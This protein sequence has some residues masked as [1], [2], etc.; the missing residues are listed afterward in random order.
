[1]EAI[2]TLIMTYAAIWAPALAAMFGIVISVVKA[3]GA[4]KKGIDAA[5]AELAKLKGEQA[6]ENAA[7][8]AKVAELEA[9]IEAYQEKLNSIL[10]REDLLLDEL[11]KVK[12]YAATIEKER[13]KRYETN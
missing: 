10:T 6:E 13:K 3:I 2:I 8:Q 9:K 4:V 1:M 11:T 7:H 12:D 5:K